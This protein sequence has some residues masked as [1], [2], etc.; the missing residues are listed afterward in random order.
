MGK[1]MTAAVAMKVLA[2]WAAIL[3]VVNGTLREAVLT[4]WLDTASALMLSGVL[5]S[6]FILGAT[7]LFLPWLGVRH[8]YQLLGVGLCWLAFTLVFEFS[9]GLLRRQTIVEILEA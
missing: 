4:P 8:P 9:L 7:Y 2:V 5:L 3:A 6:L 1:S